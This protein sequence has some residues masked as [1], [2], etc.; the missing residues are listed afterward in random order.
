MPRDA[1]TNVFLASLYY[2][3]FWIGLRR[4]RREG[5]FE[6]LD[7]SAL[8]T[9]TPWALRQPDY[10]GDCVYIHMKK[11]GSR[12]AQW[13]DIRCDYRYAFS[14]QIAPGLSGPRQTTG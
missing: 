4:Q 11:Y 6:W 10:H 5:I 7:G 13:V 8:G 1:E 3:N 14:C 9:Y 12:K 2:E